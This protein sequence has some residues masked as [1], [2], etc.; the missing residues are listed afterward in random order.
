MTRK[1]A[2][3]EHYLHP[4]LRGYSSHG[5][6]TVDRTAFA[7]IARYLTDVGALRIE[8]MDEAGVDVSVLSH[9]SPGVHMEPLAATAQRLAR[10]VNDYLAEHIARY[11]RRLE[12]FAHLSMHDPQV[13]ADELERC[14]RDLRFKGALL[15]GHT[16]GVYLDA[17]INEPFWERVQDLD[18]P[19]Y[20]HPTFPMEI[21]AAFRDYPGLDGA[22]WG[23][24]AETGGH[25]LRL[26][27]SGL[28]DRFPR[29][30]I[31]LGHMGEGLP[32]MLYRIDYG[33]QFNI[34]RVALAKP[35][36]SDYI[37]QNFYITPAAF[38]SHEALLCSIAALGVERVMFSIDAPLENSVKAS[39][40]IETAPISQEQRE[41]ICHGNAARLMNIAI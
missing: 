4:D 23:W 24:M 19:V 41:M 31:V 25:A 3:E 26:I 18:V 36:L 6:D 33:G 22:M 8:L 21:P 14:V 30:K 32:F 17:A 38:L 9:F 15:N 11:P 39:E 20:L 5:T 10:Q 34:R 28:F 27:L 7:S 1:I 40:F 2:F 13:A 12:G 37:R 16:R 29:L 35:L